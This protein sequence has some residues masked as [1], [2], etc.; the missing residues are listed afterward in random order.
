[1]IGKLLTAAQQNQHY[2]FICGSHVHT[3]TTLIGL[4]A[5][6]HFTRLHL[7]RTPHTHTYNHLP[8][9]TQHTLA[10]TIYATCI[11]VF[12][13]SLAH[14]SINLLVSAVCDHYFILAAVRLMFLTFI[15]FR[16][17]HTKRTH[18][19][20]IM[21]IIVLLGRTFVRMKS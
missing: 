16:I 14:I 8:M 20:I 21:V 11:Q 6:T 1:M 7:T 2:L 3:L 13:D 18:T 10:Y 19:H 15:F 5:F 9:W 4:S 17:H 12:G